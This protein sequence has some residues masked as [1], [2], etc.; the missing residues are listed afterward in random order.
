[1]RLPY[2]KTADDYISA[3]EKPQ[4]FAMPNPGSRYICMPGMLMP[5][6]TMPPIMPNC[7]W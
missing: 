7:M 5:G 6:V 2:L 1:M 4:P 3:F